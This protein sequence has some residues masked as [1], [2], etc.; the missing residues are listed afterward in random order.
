M[1]L[2]AVAA[3]GARAGAPSI[4]LQGVRPCVPAIMPREGALRRAQ[5]TA[6]LGLDTYQGLV[7]ARDIQST[8][9]TKRDIRP[10]ASNSG[11]RVVKE[12]KNSLREA[13]AAENYQIVW[14]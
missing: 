3:A 8:F 5:G 1:E 12:L 13:Q 4:R 7:D 14:G 2:A 10:T 9:C 6:V 11:V